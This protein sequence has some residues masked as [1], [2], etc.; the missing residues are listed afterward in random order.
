MLFPGDCVLS[1][2][3]GDPKI[4]SMKSSLAYSVMLLVIILALVSLDFLTA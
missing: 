3:V 2:V 1:R 4:R